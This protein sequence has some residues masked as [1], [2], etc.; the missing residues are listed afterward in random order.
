[1]ISRI[2]TRR[3]LVQRVLAALGELVD[4]HQWL[5]LAIAIGLAVI[6]NW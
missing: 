1:M 2:P 4:R 3:P 6:V 5:P